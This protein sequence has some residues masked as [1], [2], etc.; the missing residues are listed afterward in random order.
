MSELIRL[1]KRIALDMTRLSDS[2]SDPPCWV[3]GLGFRVSRTQTRPN[4]TVKNMGLDMSR[5]FDSVSEV[6]GLGFRL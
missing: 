2:A 4:Q 1:T 6:Q 3:Q 5:S